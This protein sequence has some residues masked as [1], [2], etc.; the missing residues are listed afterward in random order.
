MITESALYCGKILEGK[1]LPN[2]QHVQLQYNWLQTEVSEGKKLVKGIL[3]IKFANFFSLQNFP[4][5]I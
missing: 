1:I 5:M 3:F 2:E 4:R